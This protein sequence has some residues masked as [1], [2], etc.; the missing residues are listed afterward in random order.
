MRSKGLPTSFLATALLSTQA[1]VS[2]I[3]GQS[4]QDDLTG[5][6]KEQIAAALQAV[7][8]DPLFVELLRKTQERRRRRHSRTKAQRRPRKVA[9]SRRPRS[10]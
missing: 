1:D 5:S 3:L 6:G 10:G 8:Q 4:L 2:A 7:A 9:S